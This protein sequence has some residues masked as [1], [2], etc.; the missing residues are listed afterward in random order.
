[1]YACDLISQVVS[2]DLI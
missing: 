1:M 2:G